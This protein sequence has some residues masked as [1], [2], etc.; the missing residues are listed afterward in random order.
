M[1]CLNNRLSDALVNL[2]YDDCWKRKGNCDSDGSS[3]VLE[4]K[5][6]Q[7]VENYETDVDAIVEILKNSNKDSLSDEN[8]SWLSSKNSFANMRVSDSETT[9][10]EAIANVSDIETTEEEADEEASRSLTIIS[11]AR[12]CKLTS[13][14]SAVA[15]YNNQMNDQ[16]E[17][18]FEDD[19]NDN[20]LDELLEVEKSI[21]SHQKSEEAETEDLED[22][23]VEYD[24]ADDTS[25]QPADSKYLDV[26]KKYFGYSKFRQ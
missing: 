19:F 17:V 9:E 14:S 25:Y 12:S 18:D 26:L 8:S 16:S 24:Q 10:E 2:K 22:T 20:E 5:L 15:V 4:A 23:D 13:S 6:Q 11:T 3:S 21:L 7:L 1:K